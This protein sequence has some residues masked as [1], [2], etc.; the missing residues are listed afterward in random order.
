MALMTF[1]DDAGDEW[2]V[3]H[4]ETPAARAHLMDIGYREG[5]LV[6]ERQDGTD[7]RRLSGAPDDWSNLP[8][9]GLARLCARATPVT[10]GRPLTGQQPVIPPPS[11]DHSRRR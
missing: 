10:V 8:P 2:R 4:V 5:W 9:E 1:K 7:R 11:Q 6:F 3:W